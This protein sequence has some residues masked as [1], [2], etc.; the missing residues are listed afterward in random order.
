M[1]LIVAVQ[2]GQKSEREEQEQALLKLALRGR[3]DGSTDVFLAVQHVR[4]SVILCL[5]VILRP[6]TRVTL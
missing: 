6:F 5:L 1:Q 2:E 4:S 3:G